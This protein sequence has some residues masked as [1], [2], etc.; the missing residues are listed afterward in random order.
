MM[1]SSKSLNGKRVFIVEDEMIQAVILEKTIE[2]FGFEIVGSAKNG[3]NAIKMIEEL[4]PD[5]ITMDIQLEDT[6]DGINVAHKVQ[7]HYLPEVIFITGNSDSLNYSRAKEVG[8]VAFITKP[9]QVEELKKA[10]EKC[11]LLKEKGAA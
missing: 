10:L 11:V 8:F 3:E 4:R 1:D 9:V 7:Q 6:I 5:I 2:K